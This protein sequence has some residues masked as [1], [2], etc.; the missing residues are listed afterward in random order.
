VLSTPEKRKEFDEKYKTKKEKSHAGVSQKG[1]L[2]RAWMEKS[3]GAWDCFVSSIPA[4]ASIQYLTALS[5][6]EIEQMM[7]APESI[8]CTNW[9][10]AA[11]PDRTGRPIQPLSPQRAAN[12]WKRTSRAQEHG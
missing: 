11:A 6:L 3:T 9:Y 7:L 10:L 12:S 8:A 5:V 1:N 4:T 2:R